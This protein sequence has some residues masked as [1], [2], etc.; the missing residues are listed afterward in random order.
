MNT[1]MRTA[2][3]FVAIATFTVTSANAL[4]SIQVR[5]IKNTVLGFPVPEMPAMAAELV[6]KADK[7][8]KK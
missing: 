8:E 2:A 4:T 6:K 5:E 1:L 7:K 3:L